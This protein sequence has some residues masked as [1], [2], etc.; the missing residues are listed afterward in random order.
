[1]ETKSVNFHIPDILN[2]HRLNIITYETIKAHPEYFR[3]NVRIGSVYGC[4]PTAVWNGG[5][6]VPGPRTD[7]KTIKICLEDYNSRG[8][9]VRFTFTNPLITKEH[10]GN[11]YCNKLLR[12]GNNGLNEVIINSPVLEEYI[13]ANY[14]DYKITSSTCKEIRDAEGVNAELAKPYNLVVLDYNWNNNFE[15]LE[16]IKEKDRCELLVNACCIPNCKRRGDHYRSIGQE[17][18]YIEDM[19]TSPQKN[20]HK[21]ESFQCEF[22][23]QNIYNTLGYSTH[24][25]PDS[26][27]EKYVPMG[28]N[29]FKLEGRTNTDVSVLESIVYY[30]VKPELRDKVRLE[31]AEWLT[32]KNKYFI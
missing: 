31:M 17:Q 16:T 13:R 1:M 25:S 21:F 5:R 14:P 26:I 22:Q 11:P 4:F 24:I 8:I 32:E 30:M 6:I 12:L 27:Y 18:L 20:A 3:D 10:L 19:V 29:Q 2:H 28:F 7:D 9:P 23:C 15:F